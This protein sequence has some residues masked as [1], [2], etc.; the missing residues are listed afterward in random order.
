MRRRGRGEC[1][2]G[3][4]DLR[5]EERRLRHEGIGLGPDC[6]VR[7]HELCCA[8]RPADPG[9]PLVRGHIDGISGALDKSAIAAAVLAQFGISYG[10]N[11][12]AD[13]ASIVAFI[14]SI[15]PNASVS[16]EGVSTDGSHFYPLVTP[17][18]VNYQFLIPNL[19]HVGIF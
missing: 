4:G 10:I 2:C 6:A 19:S 1:R 7:R 11:Q 15:A 13:T 14:K 12:P 8:V 5:Q 3:R 17:T 16:A 9:E 18:G